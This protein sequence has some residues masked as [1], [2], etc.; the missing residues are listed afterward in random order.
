MRR[1]ITALLLTSCCLSQACN[2]GS[3]L[4]SVGNPTGQPEVPERILWVSPEAGT[5][6][7]GSEA[8]PFQ[9]LEQAR[10]AVRAL[11]GPWEGDVVITLRGGTH[12]LRQPLEL[13]PLDSGQDGQDVVYRSAVGERAVISGAIRITGWQLTDPG[14]GIF[15]AFAGQHPTRQLYVNGR[16][17]IR[18]RTE[19]YP[20]GFLPAFVWI[21]GV[22]IKLG[23][24]FI[25]TDLNPA[26]WRDPA[27]WTNVR[28]IEAVI[29]T[30]WKQM[31]VKVASVTPYPEFTIDPLLQPLTLLLP[32]P[33]P[34]KTGLITMQDPGWTNA[35][36]FL[37]R[38]TMQPGPWS[39]W[40]VT[41][42]ENAYE[43]LDQPGEWYLNNATGYLYYIPRPGEDMATA[44]VELPVLERL[45]DGQ[46]TSAQPLSHI[47]FEGLTFTGATWLGPSSPDGYVTDQSAFHLVGT[48]HK[49]NIWGHD[50]N[51]VRTPGNLYFRFARNIGF[52][53]NIFEHLG[54]VALDFDTGSQ[55]NRIEQNLFTDI[56]SS[57]IVLGGVAPEDARPE[58]PAQATSDNLIAGNL[59]RNVATD[60]VDAAGIFVG[61]TART[62]IVSNTVAEVPWSG[63]AMGWGWGLL[64]KGMFPG[65]PGSV[66]GEW[67]TYTTP[68]AN[69][70]NK[71]QKNR[72]YAWGNVLWDTGAIYTTGQQGTSAEDAL[73]I[74]GNVATNK[75]PS[76]GSNVFYTD[77]GSR[78]I[79]L[80][81]NVSIDNP[82]GIVWFGPLA[83]ANDPLP[84]P[85]IGLANCLPYGGEIGGCVTYG[86]I[87]YAD[88]YAQT[89]WTDSNSFYNPC[90]YQAGGVTYPTNLQF[91]GNRAISSLADVPAELVNAAGVQTRPDTIPAEKWVLPPAGEPGEK[92]VTDCPQPRALKAEFC[93]ANGA[94]DLEKILGQFFR[95]RPAP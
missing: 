56:A 73:L 3:Q 48:N 60:Y 49:P 78:Y 69:S 81:K 43:F 38:D 41:R 31:S 94:L 61:F 62:T 8:A 92:T 93:G 42:F 63:I 4:V 17:A 37:L 50:Q 6:G 10:D 82:V 15:A 40:Q 58:H 11:E 30:Q 20:S 36:E 95:S 75:R 72:F 18:A 16:R 67:G 65:N 22:P 29:V 21:L 71:I 87:S 34:V 83:K 9:T 25:P 12:R 70:G 32:R 26:G 89:A 91:A 13:G 55:H 68:T 28:D 45:V 27:T 19:D 23:I 35:N 84:Y 39:F 57:A 52:F 7:D 79:S 33:Q 64:D 46:G 1:F 90:P 44:E 74:E 54:S 53:G 66:S 14:R 77:G 76:A 51:V 2:S 85:P 86:D 59:V 5:E 24:E 47:R 88:N 80:R